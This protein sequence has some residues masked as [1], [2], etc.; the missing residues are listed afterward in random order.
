M[1]PN[2]CIHLTREIVIEIHAEAIAQFGGSEGLRDLTMLESAVAAPQA[3]FGG[4][5]PFTDGIDVAA[6]YLFYLCANHPFVDGNK[7][8]ALGACLVF[9][10]L[11]GYEPAPDDERWENLTMA[12]AA[13]VLTRDEVTA[14]LRDLVV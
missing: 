12:V 2:K 4:V 5:S 10:Q 13:G 7:R 6:G 8:M 9:L 14:K 11:N 3:T 1:D